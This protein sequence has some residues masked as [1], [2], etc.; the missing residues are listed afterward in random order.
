MITC[1]KS[2]LT[3]LFSLGVLL[4]SDRCTWGPAYWCES[5]ENV[6]ECGK[7]TL[8]HC[9]NKVWVGDHPLAGIT[10][11]IFED[12]EKENKVEGGVS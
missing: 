6:K 5:V 2:P 9:R 4:G 12:E 10:D 3:P 11:P 7:N 1:N 8:E